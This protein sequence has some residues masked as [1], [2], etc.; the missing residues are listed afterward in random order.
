[1]SLKC[2]CLWRNEKGVAHDFY[3]K[4]CR[5]PKF[6]VGIVYEYLKVINY[7][8]ILQ[9][10]C[11]KRNENRVELFEWVL[12]EENF[13][14]FCRAHKFPWKNSPT[15]ICRCSLCQMVMRFFYWNQT[16]MCCMMVKMMTWGRK[17][18]YIT[19]RLEEYYK[20]RWKVGQ[21]KSERAGRNFV[22]MTS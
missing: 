17:F 2:H 18:C 16:Q 9:F 12:R 3:E 21:H 5:W 19:T 14:F 10:M 13:H 6:L 1:M 20:C 22:L 15:H 7:K 11:G 8:K 4:G